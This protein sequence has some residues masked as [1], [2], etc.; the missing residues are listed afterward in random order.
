MNI[1]HNKQ[2]RMILHGAGA[3]GISEEDLERRALEIAVIN[4][5]NDA[6]EDD[7]AEAFAE[8]Q[9]QLLPPTSHDDAE[10]LGALSRDPSEPPAMSG[11]ET[12]SHEGDDED[13]AVERLATEGVEEAQHD[14]MLASRRREHR[15]SRR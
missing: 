2:S 15:E 3:G 7:R 6:T 8:L 9:G 14:Q 4:G 5:R 1:K 12:P 10:S 11:R 13:Q